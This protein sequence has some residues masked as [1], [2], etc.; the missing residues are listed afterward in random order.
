MGCSSLGD[1]AHRSYRQ[2]DG[3]APARKCADKLA[4]PQGLDGLLTLWCRLGNDVAN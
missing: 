1:L 2:V 4:E 3:L